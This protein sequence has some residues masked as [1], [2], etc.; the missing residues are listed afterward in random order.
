LLAAALAIVEESDSSSVRAKA[1]QGAGALAFFQRDYTSA[2]DLLKESLVIFRELEDKQGTAWTKIYQGWLANDSG[3]FELGLALFNES[4]TLFREL[5]DKQGIAWSLSRLGAVASFQ[6]DWDT[7][8]PLVEESL[9]L[10]REV[11]DPIQTGFSLF[12]LSAIDLNEGNLS[13]ARIFGEE[14]ETIN[15]SLGNQRN[16]TY[17][18]MFLAFVEMEEGNTA[19]A[20]SLF[21]ESLTYSVE[22]G[23]SWA[24]MWLLSCFVI[25]DSAVSQPDRAAC[26]GGAIA[27]LRETIEGPLPATHEYMLSTAL[28][29][30]RSELGAK[31]ESVWEQGRSMTM[32]QAIEYALEEPNDG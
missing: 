20:R 25:L 16:L 14:S 17:A 22:L 2:K 27:S 4:L 6:G 18:L 31:A 8:R 1:F 29:S 13:S 11:R 28:E 23:D 12:M 24:C 30:V 19:K 21:K 26:L 32:E 3:E 5:G 15:R 9:A 7:A 10:S